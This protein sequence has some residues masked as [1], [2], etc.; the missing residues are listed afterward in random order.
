[1]KHDNMNFLELEGQLTGTTRSGCDQGLRRSA[2]H[3]PRGKKPSLVGWI[4]INTSGKPQLERALDYYLPDASR[5]RGE[6]RVAGMSVQEHHAAGDAW[7][8][9]RHSAITRGWSM[10][11]ARGVAGDSGK[12]TRG[13][14]TIVDRALGCSYCNGCTTADFPPPDSPGRLSA[15][16]THGVLKGGIVTVSIYLHDSESKSGRN[17]QLLDRAA[18]LVL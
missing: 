8:N 18:E 10:D 9:L 13:T 14:A 12:V 16:W 17:T 6:R 2:K 3:R 7:T 1:M 4:S 11:G 15:V 5:R